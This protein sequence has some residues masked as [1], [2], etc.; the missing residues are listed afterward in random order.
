MRVK[1]VKVDF[2]K[3]ILQC[4][5]LSCLAAA[6][7]TLTPRRTST[8]SLTTTRRSSG[9]CTASCRSRGPRPPSELSG[10]TDRRDRGAATHPQQSLVVNLFLYGFRRDVL[11][12]TYEELLEPLDDVDDE[13]TKNNRTMNSRDKRQTDYPGPVENSSGK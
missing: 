8:S 2:F 6:R 1:I 5:S 9:G 12:G 13:S 11:E 3:N 7:G 4:W 10:P